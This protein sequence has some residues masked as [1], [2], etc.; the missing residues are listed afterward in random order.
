MASRPRYDNL[1]NFVAS[2][3]FNTLLFF[4]IIASLFVVAITAGPVNEGQARIL[5]QDADISP[6]G[7]YQ[8][9]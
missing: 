2:V 6:D 4:Q 7:S 8:W 5:R 1:L 3:L 9:A